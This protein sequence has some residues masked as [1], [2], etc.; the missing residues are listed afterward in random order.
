MSDAAII[1]D[2]EQFYLTHPISLRQILDKLKAEGIS[3]EDLHEDLLQAHD[4]DHFG[5]VAANDVLADFAGLH[6]GTKVLDLCCGLGGP[7]R[8][9][10]QNY[11]CCVTGLD[12]TESRVDG[13]RALT[14]MTGLSERVGFVQGNA[15]EMPFGEASFDVVIGQEAFCHIADKGR[16]I[17]EC[18]RVLRR[19][20]RLAFTDILATGETT[21]ATRERLE[22]EMTF[23]ALNTQGDY[24]QSMEG[25]GLVVDCFEDLSRTWEA[26]LVDRLAM[27]RGLKAQTVAAFGE[28]HFRKWDEAY[29]HFVACYASGELGG[30]RFLARR[31]E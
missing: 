6:A 21:R 7:A 5:G 16:L 30:G 3:L 23:H 27:Y 1:D 17:D 12:L 31:L 2:V 24:L 18:A 29:A 13:A 15:L 22:R 10:A 20:G 26:I 25:A 19:G 8:Y 11:G 9:L 28:A 4:Q 14:R